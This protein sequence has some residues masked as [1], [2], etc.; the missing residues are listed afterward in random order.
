M[1]RFLCLF[2]ISFMLLSLTGCGSKNDESSKDNSNDVAKEKEEEKET[3]K[4]NQELSDVETFVINEQDVVGVKKD[5]TTVMIMKGIAKNKKMHSIEYADGKIYISNAET[6]LD[7]PTKNSRSKMLVA[8]KIWYDE[9]DLTRGDGNYVAVKVYEYDNEDL[10]NTLMPAPHV[11]NGK[12]YIVKNANE[13]ISIDLGTKEVEVV[14]SEISKK[15]NN[16]IYGTYIYLDKENGNLFYMGPVG[17]KVSLAKYDLKTNKREIIES[18][19]N[20][21]FHFWQFT[22]DGMI[23]DVQHYDGDYNME[24]KKYTFSDNKVVN[25]TDSY[26]NAYY[27]CGDNYVVELDAGAV[28]DYDFGP[29]YM[30]IVVQDKNFKEVKKIFEKVNNESAILLSPYTYDKVLVSD[31]KKNYILDCTS[32]ELKETSNMYTQVAIV[33]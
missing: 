6:K 24:V 3:I 27:A 29:H 11:Y 1:K 5:G 28:Y 9:I 20:V 14:D 15:L 8:K 25:L 18:N 31:G 16:T 7:Y 33:K 2:V 12:L 4:L 32:L 23:F 21:V 13:I 19:N 26:V 17:D 10:E 22:K 30:N